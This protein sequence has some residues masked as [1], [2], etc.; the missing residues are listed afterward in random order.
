MVFFNWAMID[1]HPYATGFFEKVA[2]EID[3]Q[4]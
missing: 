4:S 3:S 2:K 1:T